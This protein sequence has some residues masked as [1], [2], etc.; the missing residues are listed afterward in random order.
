MKLGETAGKRSWLLEANV[1]EEADDDARGTWLQTAAEQFYAWETFYKFVKWHQKF[2]HVNNCLTPTSFTYTRFDHPDYRKAM[3]CRAGFWWGHFDYTQV[4]ERDHGTRFVIPYWF[5]ALTFSRPVV[6]AAVRVILKRRKTP[7]NT[8]GFEVGGPQD[9]GRLSRSAR[10]G[11]LLPPV[12]PLMASR[13]RKTK[14]VGRSD[15]R[16]SGSLLSEGDFS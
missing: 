16:H 11:L 14:A 9:L 15:R 2:R 10:C 7:T 6:L 13:R 12:R 5:R 8:S 4:A 3:K 1:D